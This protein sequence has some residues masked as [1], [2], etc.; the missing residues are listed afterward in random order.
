MLTMVTIAVL[1][2]IY[3]MNR[4]F[5]RI[6]AAGAMAVFL[7][8]VVSLIVIATQSSISLL[9]GGVNTFPQATAFVP[10]QSPAMVSLSANPEK[11]YGIRQVNLPLNQRHSDRQEWLQW[12]TSLFNRIGLDYQSDLKPW[13]GDEITL[14]ITALDF[15]RNVDNGTQPGYLLVT[16]SKNTQLAQEL[17]RNFYGEQKNTSLEQYKGANIIS[18][19]GSKTLKEPDV[20]AN[21]VVGRFVLFANYPQILKE[22]INQAQAVNLNLEQSD[23]YQDAIANIKQPHIGVAYINVP[24]TSAWLDKL[25]I[26]DQHSEN[27]TLSAVISIRYRNLA[28]QTRLTGVSD[29]V[30]SNEAYKSLINNSE[31]EEIIDSLPLENK[32]YMDL[33]APTSLLKEQIPRYEVTR[34]AIKAL[35]PHLEEI[36]IQNKGNQDNISRTEIL[37]QLDA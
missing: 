2:H 17:I 28:V 14:A 26:V 36:A 5:L 23:Y 30:A 7:I 4:F 27:Q 11:I 10:K 8:S 9:G 31:L 12:T 16:E 20:W 34:L 15:D 19:S 29:S 18:Q 33:T 6:L 1:R 37:F 24:G 21:A 13:L 35:F 3:L 22:A 25:G 32:T